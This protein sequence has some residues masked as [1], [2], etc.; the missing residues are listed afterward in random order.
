MNYEALQSLG[1]K[2]KNNVGEQ[3]TA[4]PKCSQSRKHKSDP[5]L[6]VNVKEGIYNCHNCGWHGA[7]R[8]PTK[9][10]NRPISELKK[11]SDQVINWFGSRGISNQ[12]ILRYK[13]TES[14]EYMPQT[15]AEA[16]CINF[17]YFFYGTLVNIKFRDSSKNFKL[18]S[19]AMLSLYGIDVAIDNS[20][21]ELVI[22]EG[23][24]DTLSFYEAGIKTAVSVPNGA[25]KG[26]QKLEWL[27]ELYH[28]FDGR[29][30][31]LATDTDEAGL[32]LRNEIARRLGKQNCL[33]ISF[34]SD[35]KDANEVLL[36]HGKEAL[37]E[38]YEN[39]T[40]FP[41]EGVEDASNVDLMA[42]Y[43]QGMPE[44]VGIGWDMDDE[45]K[46]C[47]GQVSLV[48]GIPGHGKSTWIKNV[49]SR[50]AREHGWKSFIYSAEEASTEFALTDMISIDSGLSFFDSPYCKRISKDQ[51]NEL[52]PFMSEH[53]K[54]LKLHDNDLTAEGILKKGEEMVKRYGIRAFI[55]DNMST[56]EKGI[57]T[58]GESRHN[59]IQSILKEFVK[60]A[61]HYG[62]H[63][64]LVAHP[65]K[66]SKSNGVYDIPNGYDVGDSSHYFNL[67][68]NGLT[69]YRNLQTGLT[70]IHKWKV[71][72]K[73]TGQLGTEHFK[74]DLCNG[75]YESSLKVNNGE[76]KTKFK[77][78]PTDYNRFITAG[79]T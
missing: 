37:K 7:I 22:T 64:F 51:V 78:Q 71:R 6:S 34:P 18:V 16:R 31:L 17:N 45:F 69:V 21:S 60:F 36:K 75:R 33:I 38:C 10:Y 19:G 74:Y 47:T 5:C 32:S 12:T 26:N 73:Y 35:C 70:E 49:I 43:D 53:F 72:F 77:G 50:L 63:V 11:L 57:P 15:S 56:V 8:L 67:P 24:M 46:W 23:E 55:I 41:I 79:T 58:A 20:D 65:K 27:E 54:Y 40:P 66:M 28:V 68:D 52:M 59:A 3:K 25:S 76:D 62:V 29:K 2:C 30:I 14:I 13:I 44:G 39:A 48:T 9:E 4:C 42:L 61:R 1:I